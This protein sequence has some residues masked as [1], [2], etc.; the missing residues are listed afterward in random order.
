MNADEVMKTL[1]QASAT[2]LAGMYASP[3]EEVD[4]DK[5][6]QNAIYLMIEAEEYT[7]GWDDDSKANTKEEAV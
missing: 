3:H 1:V 2:I 5:A 4:K 6:F 7:M